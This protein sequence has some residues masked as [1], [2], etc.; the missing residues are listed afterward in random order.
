MLIVYI[1][2][3]VLS[4]CLTL[5]WQ[6]HIQLAFTQDT[7]PVPSSSLFQ[8]LSHF[9]SCSFLNAQNLCRVLHPVCWFS[10]ISVVCA[11]C[12]LEAWSQLEML[13]PI[14]SSLPTLACPG[15]YCNLHAL[16]T[17]PHPLPDPHWWVSRTT[18]AH[19]AYPKLILSHTP[20]AL[21]QS[22]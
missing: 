18:P 22:G 3:S 21:N 6:Y 8:F 11:L 19:I 13:C 14:W 16:P 12:N 7:H 17:A 2:N 9:P 15:Y 1:V 20:C 4:T 5:V 10:L